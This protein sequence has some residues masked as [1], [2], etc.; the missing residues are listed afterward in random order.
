[1][2]MPN[3]DDEPS[4][5][6]SMYLHTALFRLCPLYMCPHAASF[7]LSSLSMC[8]HAASF[9]LSSLLI[10]SN[11]SEAGNQATHLHIKGSEKPTATQLCLIQN[12]PNL[13]EQYILPNTL[14][15]TTLA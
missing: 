7:T 12:F 1:M 4:W 10:K 3:G 6:T 13:L 11:I 9:R 2:E 14:L 5:E 8:P 15:E